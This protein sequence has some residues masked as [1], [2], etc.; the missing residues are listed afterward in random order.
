MFQTHGCRLGKEWS[1]WLCIFLIA[2]TSASAHH[3]DGRFA[4]EVRQAANKY[5]PKCGEPCRWEWL[6]A[7]I[8][9]ES[10]YNPE[11]R[12]P[13]GA[14]GL[15][16]AMPPTWRHYIKRG[17]IPVNATRT[18]VRWSIIGAARY[19]TDR[20]EVW[21][22]EG[23]S[24]L[25]RWALGRG[26]FNAGCRNLTD[27]QELCGGT[28]SYCGIM[29]CLPQVTAHHSQETIHYEISIR[30]RYAGFVPNTALDLANCG[31]RPAAPGPA[32]VAALTEA[33]E[34]PLAMAKLGPSE[35]VPM[36]EIAEP[37]PAPEPEPVKQ[38]EQPVEEDVGMGLILAAAFAALLLG[39][40]IGRTVADAG[41]FESRIWW[42]LT[43]RNKASPIF[44]AA[45]AVLVPAWFIIWP[46]FQ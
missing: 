28:R 23:R 7:Q 30:R 27:A 14:L 37:E 8:G 11:A 6:Y 19:M 36:P 43:F 9:Q 34:L 13:A 16:Q 18:D 39:Y 29:E 40:A 25:E 1:A 45:A 10:S 17:W 38:P 4:V 44:Y 33:L 31:D 46:M 32:V 12:S 20:M 42:T 21:G 5:W 15:G 2:A 41:W 22:L 26:C 35:P 24:W 3:E